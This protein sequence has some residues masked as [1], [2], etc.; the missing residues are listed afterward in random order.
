MI[1][2][3]FFFEASH[4]SLF[5]DNKTISIMH[6]FKKLISNRYLK[7]NHLR[8]ILKMIPLTSRNQNMI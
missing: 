8:V 5:N 4:L 3:S 2:F 6:F 7:I 1:I